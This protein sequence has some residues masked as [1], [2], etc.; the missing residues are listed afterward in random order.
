MKRID[1]IVNEACQEELDRLRPEP[2]DERAVLQ[3][4]LIKL[5]LEEKKDREA[6]GV[7]EPGEEGVIVA[8]PV[9]RH[10]GFWK[11]AAAVAAC[12]VLAVGISHLVL[13]G[14]LHSGGPG[15]GP[16]SSQNAISQVASFPVDASVRDGETSGN[17]EPVTL[18]FSIQAEEQNMTLSHFAASPAG[19]E[20]TLR[21]N[22]GEQGKE[23][24]P[25]EFCDARLIGEDGTSRPLTRTGEEFVQEQEG[26]WANWIW[27]A[28]YT[29]EE[30]IPQSEKAITVRAIVKGEKFQQSDLEVDFLV[31]LEK[32]TVTVGDKLFTQNLVSREE[33]AFDLSL[34]DQPGA[35]TYEDGVLCLND[36]KAFTNLNPNS[37]SVQ[38]FYKITAGYNLME[39][40]QGSSL[41]TFR[42]WKETEPGV[43]VN[44][45][46]RIPLDQET[47][48]VLEDAPGSVDG[49]LHMVVTYVTTDRDGAKQFMEDVY[50]CLTAGSSGDFQGEAEGGAAESMPPV[51]GSFESA[52][53]SIAPVE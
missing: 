43:W 6:P 23:L 7:Q 2:V 25:T 28:C 39:H 45:Q 35:V 34:A 22:L 19:T 11:A 12:G 20:F 18:D 51:E 52:V 32:K 53:S 21:W 17:S 42:N 5:G 8:H 44:E 24:D 31:D 29:T 15:A 4:T 36:L 9:R 46:I 40:Y 48:A 33:A 16:E 47:K 50:F 3:K 10:W 26:E 49:V 41:D 30:T 14:V 37:E 1:E 38:Y 27:S 13:P